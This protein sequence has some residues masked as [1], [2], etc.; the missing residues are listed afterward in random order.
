MKYL[1]GILVILTILSVGSMSFSADYYKE[2]PTSA[3]I[4]KGIQGLKLKSFRGDTA[5]AVERFANEWLRDNPNITIYS[6]QSLNS[7]GSVRL[8]IWYKP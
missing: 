2:S 5:F 3:A 4:E 8:F 1:I 6:V 7:W